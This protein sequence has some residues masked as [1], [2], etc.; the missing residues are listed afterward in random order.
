MH[1]RLIHFLEEAWS[2]LIFALKEMFSLKNRVPDVRNRQ[3]CAGSA[4][5]NAP[6]CGLPR[7][8]PKPWHNCVLQMQSVQ[9]WQH[10]HCNLEHRTFRKVWACWVYALGVS[11]RIKRTPTTKTIKKS[12][13][14]GMWCCV[15]INPPTRKRTRRKQ[16]LP[17]LLS[18]INHC[19]C[20]WCQAK[21]LEL[22]TTYE[23]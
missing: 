9:I 21:H 8:G 18:E 10:Y 14:T 16:E 17:Q 11:S 5:P 2:A 6:G 13:P 1:A 15:P 23:P 19:E 7:V 3:G 20:D 22:V 12:L 4:L